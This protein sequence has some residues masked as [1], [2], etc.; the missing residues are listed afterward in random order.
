MQSRLYVRSARRRASENEFIARLSGI[1][2]ASPAPCPHCDPAESLERGAVFSPRCFAEAT[3]RFSPPNAKYSECRGRKRLLSKKPCITESYALMLSHSFTLMQEC[4]IKNEPISEAL[5]WLLSHESGLSPNIESHTRAGGIGQLIGD[6][7]DFLGEQK[8]MQ[9]QISFTA[10]QSSKGMPDCKRISDLINKERAFDADSCS[11]TRIPPNPLLGLIW[12]YM[13]LKENALS[14]ERFI[15]KS[16]ASNKP[17][18]TEEA[19]AALNELKALAT[20]QS[21][22][23]GWGHVLG[24]YRYALK[25]CRKPGESGAECLKKKFKSFTY[26]QHQKRPK[27]AKEILHYADHVISRKNEL[28]KAAQESGVKCGSL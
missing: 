13:T 28:Q 3:R 7:I 17:I 14:F 18:G 1:N 27:R 24:G 12:A 10:S 15:K 21:Y 8:K 19:C 25:S 22:N 26:A 11:R 16:C 20:M 9:N 6:Q 2:K 4:V 5:F 23:A